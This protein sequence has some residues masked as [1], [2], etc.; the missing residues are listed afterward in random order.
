MTKAG[1]SATTRCELLESNHEAL[2]NLE[3]EKRKQPGLLRLETLTIE[4]RK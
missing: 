1:F 4:G 2:C 3:N